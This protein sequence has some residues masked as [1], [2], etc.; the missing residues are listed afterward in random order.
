MKKLLLIRHAKA[1]HDTG[2][3]DFERPLKK[4]GLEDAGI[5]AA[6][7]KDNG[8]VPQM[9]ISSPALRAISTANVMVEHLSLAQPQTEMKIYEASQ[10]TLLSI[11]HALPDNYHFIGLAGHNPGFS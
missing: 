4:S 5:I 3:E 1:T 2:Y 10:A 7:L 9:F 8:V 11:V 6:R